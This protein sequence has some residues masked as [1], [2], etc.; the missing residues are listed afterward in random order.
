MKKSIWYANTVLYNVLVRC[1]I[2]IGEK[3]RSR[4]SKKKQELSP[5]IVL[6]N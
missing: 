5:D 4:M 3:E 2:K 6:K 1:T